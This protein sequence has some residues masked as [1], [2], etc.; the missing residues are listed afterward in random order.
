M[1]AEAGQQGLDQL[2][3]VGISIHV[4]SGVLCAS[5]FELPQSMVASG[6]SDYLLGSALQCKSSSQKG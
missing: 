4:V 6:Q 1:V 3:M 2:M 5:W